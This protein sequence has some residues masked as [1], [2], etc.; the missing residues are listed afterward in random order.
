MV[1]TN[2]G[3]QFNVKSLTERCSTG[4]KQWRGVGVE[5]QAFVPNF[6]L[7]P[8]AWLGAVILNDIMLSAVWLSVVAP[9]LEPTPS[10]VL[11]WIPLWGLAYST[12]FM[13]LGFTCNRATLT[14][15]VQRSYRWAS[16]LCRSSSLLSSLGQLVQ[17]P[18]H[19]IF[20]FCS[21]LHEWECL[22]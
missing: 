21:G 4:K 13:E 8:F 1:H 16:F 18:V 12:F 3:V 22:I 20:I 9:K 11:C 17:H 7:N 5:T 6:K 14:N 10:E 2:W 15:F 19:F